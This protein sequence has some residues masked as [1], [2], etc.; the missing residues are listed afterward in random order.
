VADA[1]LVIISTGIRQNVDL[2]KALGLEIKRS[3]VV[4][5]KMETGIA[6]IYAC[7]DCAEFEGTNYAIWPQAIDMGRVAG[8]NAVGDEKQYTTTVPAVTFNGMRTSIFSIGDIGKTEGKK[9]KTK[10]FCDEENLIYK[11]LYFLNGRFCGGILIG[12]TKDQKDLMIALEEK[13]PIDKM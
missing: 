8:A 12:D 13:T 3:I 9:Y 4:N 6:N 5:N 11:K 7:G 1:Q 2:A 10:E